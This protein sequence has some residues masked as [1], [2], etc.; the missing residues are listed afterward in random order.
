M[1]PPRPSP[2][3]VAWLNPRQFDFIR[4]LIYEHSKITLEDCKNDLVH[5]RLGK[6]LRALGLDSYDQYCGLLRSA[7]GGPE[8]QFLIAA[9]STNHTFFF[10]EEK[11]FEFLHNIAV[12]GMLSLVQRAKDRTLRVWSA[13]SSSGEEPY[14]LAMLLNE[15]PGLAGPTSW[16]LAATDISHEIL[17]SAMAGIYDLD[18]IRNVPNQWF[19]RYF[20]LGKGSTANK[21]RIRP[22]LQ[23]KINFGQLNLFQ[24]DYP[25]ERPFHII[26]CRNV[27]IYF[28]RQDRERL[29]ARLH[30]CLVP[31]G[32]LMVGHSESLIGGQSA[33]ETIQAAIYQKPL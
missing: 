12:P 7:D 21:C 16:E 4:D 1:T 8:L 25:F 20:L 15:H 18:R 17:R 33:F 14:S 13:A 5:S 11:H 2:M 32:Y 10:R 27:M 3:T 19:R 30:D 29:V 6:R 23:R 22:E 26:F 9:I 28:N 24:P 31:G